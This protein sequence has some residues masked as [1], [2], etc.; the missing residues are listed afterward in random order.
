MRFRAAPLTSIG[1]RDV[2]SPFYGLDIGVSA[3]RAAQ[4][5]LDTAAHNVANANTPGYSR[6]RVSLVESPPYTFPA[7]NRS[8]LPGQIGSGVTVTAITRVRDNFLDLQVQAQT[9]LQG[10]W[11]T[12]QQQLAKVEAVFPEPSDTGLGSTLSK[13]WNAWQDVASDP[14]S[15]AA[16]TALT[17]QASSLAMEMNRDSTQLKMIASGIDSQ[18]GQQIQTVNDLATQIA[19]LNSQIQRVTITGDHAND[20]MDQREQL[21]EQLSSIVPA[22]VM[23]QQDGSI[24]VLVGGTDLVSGVFARKMVAQTDQATGQTNPVWA[25]GGAVDLPSGQMKA[26]IDVRDTDLA[27][28]L[29]QLDSL[30]KG[31]ADA[32]NTL[33]ER[34]IDANGAAGQAIFTYH[35]GNEAGTLAVN[36]TIAADPRLVAAAAS[37]G[38]PG[39]SSVAG[40]I[41]DLRNARSYSAGV[42]GTDVVGGMDL[43]TNTTAR[44]MVV[45]AST[46][47]AQTYTFSA[48]GSSLTL[49]GAD[50]TTQ[51]VDVADM[52]ANGTQVLNFD[53]LGVKLTVNAGAAGK[54]GADLATDLA[55]TGHNTLVATSLFTPS[56]TASEYFASFVG[57]I[58]SASA[59]S[60]EMSKNQQ[61]VVDQLTA[62]VQEVSG[63]SLD[64]EATDMIRFQH[65]YQAAAR[66]ITTMDEI[67]DTLINKVGL[68]GR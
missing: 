4:Q 2:S 24:S 56:Q 45:S 67:L 44:L 29:G 5:L 54:A 36:P 30:A 63:V 47:T 68:V 10:E 33:H 22:H 59:Q 58:G 7:F 53:Q 11:D 35:A 19:A 14:T 23:T 15:T 50:G 64:E 43:T 27:G 31:L 21:L 49:T 46:A 48:N 8:G 28:Y 6:Q 12:R 9:A 62:R 20:L 25:D 17:E 42:A 13:F 61:L 1:A 60:S 38:T 65:A 3:L 39:D 37:A 32:T 55:M 34:G 40:L 57:K 41:A 66:V 51:T 18:V 26:L 52:A 16:R